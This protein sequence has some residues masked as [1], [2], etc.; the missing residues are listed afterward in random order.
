MALSRFEIASPQQREAPAGAAEASLLS[1]RDKAERGLA[2]GKISRIPRR[3]PL[4]AWPR[5]RKVPQKE[6]QEIL[7]M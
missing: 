7:F 3:G 6:L 5:Q 2:S 4:F 1:N